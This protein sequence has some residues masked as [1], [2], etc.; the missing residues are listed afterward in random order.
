M[1]KNVQLSAPIFDFV[2]GKE[3]GTVELS[4]AVFGVEVKPALVHQVLVALEANSRQTLA[5]TKTKAEVRGGGIKPRPQK[6]SGR[7]RQGS[8]RNPQ[9]AG[10]GVAHGPKKNR[11]FSLKV[12]KKM[13]SQAVKMVLADRAQH[14]AF[15]VLRNV[16]MPEIKTKIARERLAGLPNG[17]KST[18]I[19]MPATDIAVV[20]SFR[21]LPGVKILRAGDASI[22]DLLRYK[23]V[24]V[25]EAALES[26]VN[27]LSR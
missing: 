16:A 25:A 2:T 10:G 27:R 23:N 12:N 17:G 4:P 22:K 7:S 3:V 19:L 1:A 21:N 5:H 9:W 20:K 15:A 26:L 11:N 8:T 6:G 13:V 14:D 24:F 18:A